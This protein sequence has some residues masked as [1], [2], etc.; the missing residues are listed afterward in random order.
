MSFLHVIEYADAACPQGS[1][2]AASWQQEPPFAQQKVAI[3]SS[4]RRQRQTRF[5]RLERHD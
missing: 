1:A 2:G 5:V 3:G 4:S